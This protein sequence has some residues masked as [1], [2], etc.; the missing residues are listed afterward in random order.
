MYDLYKNATLTMPRD[1][2]YYFNTLVF[3][4]NIYTKLKRSFKDAVHSIHA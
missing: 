3:T 4:V 1:L 2:R